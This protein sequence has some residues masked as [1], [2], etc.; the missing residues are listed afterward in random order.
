MIITA[1]LI[2]VTSEVIGRPDVDQLFEL[3]SVA[4]GRHQTGQFVL[5]TLQHAIHRVAAFA[6]AHVVAVV[7][8]VFAKA[9]QTGDVVEFCLLQDA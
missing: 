1:V 9:N 6:V 4:H 3:P 8:A 5:V 2:V 7:N